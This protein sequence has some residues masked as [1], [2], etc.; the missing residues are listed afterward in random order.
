MTV[1]TIL[2]EKGRE[3]ETAGGQMTIAEAADRLTRKKIGS[4]V[5]VDDGKRIR[6]ILSERDIVQALAVRGGGALEAPISS[7]MTTAVKVCSEDSTVNEVMEIMTHGRF[8]HL[9]VE[10]D[11]VLAGIVSIGDVVRKR[12][13]EIERETE[14]IK[15]YIAS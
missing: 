6:G 12:I 7:A 5:V 14:E 1:R 2:D 8:R 13:E 15:A 9:P 3:V 4:I 10:K 11:G